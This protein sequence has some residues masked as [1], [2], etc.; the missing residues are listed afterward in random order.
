MPWKGLLSSSQTFIRPGYAHPFFNGREEALSTWLRQ[1]QAFQDQIP[2]LS[3]EAAANLIADVERIRSETPNAERILYQAGTHVS[4][5]FRAVAVNLFNQHGEVDFGGKNQIQNTIA[6]YHRYHDAD[7]FKRVEEFKK[8]K[9]R[10]QAPEF[11][12][13]EQRQAPAHPIESKFNRTHFDW[14][15]VAD[16]LNMLKNETKKREKSTAQVARASYDFFQNILK[17]KDE[18]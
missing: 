9:Q 8:L 1:L 18:V 6:T 2:Q 7:A 13:Q 3:E 11:N 4:N 16:Y 15:K 10:Y 14:G 12:K 5:K 17:R